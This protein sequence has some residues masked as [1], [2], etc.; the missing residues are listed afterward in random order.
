MA[1]TE[2]LSYLDNPEVRISRVREGFG[3]CLAGT[4]DRLD[5][6]LQ[7]GNQLTDETDEWLI[8]LAGAEVYT[9]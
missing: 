9:L 8:H 3:L 4:K 1:G 5:T 7:F 2:S 6:L